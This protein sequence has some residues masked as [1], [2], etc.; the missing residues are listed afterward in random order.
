MREIEKKNQ[1]KNLGLLSK[2]GISRTKKIKKIVR[3]IPR[4]KKG[5]KDI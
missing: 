4:R 5:K 2:S 3:T 1:E